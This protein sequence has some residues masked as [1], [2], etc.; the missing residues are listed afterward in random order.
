M[1]DTIL[2]VD[3]E[4]DL[5]AGLSRSI[6]MEL[7]CDILTADNAGTALEIIYG[8]PVDL[9]L[10]DIS[11]P[12]KNGMEL[13]QEISGKKPYVTV[14]MMTG[15]G[16]IEIAVESIKH[17]AYDFIQKPFDMQPLVRLLEKG[18]ERNRLIRENTRLS[19]L[20]GNK[21]P[22]LNMIGNSPPMHE[23][24]AKINMLAK[25]DVTVLITGETGTGKE[26]AARAVHGSSSRGDNAMITVNCPAL[27]EN[28][29]ES[30][31]FGYKKGAF[32]GALSDKTGLFDQADGSTIFLDEIGDLSMAVQTKLLRVLQDKTIMPL[33]ATRSH[34]VNVRI[35][36][37]TNRNLKRK[38]RN[39]TFR[40]DLYY[41][42]NVAELSM[43]PLRRVREDIPLLTRH[44][45]EKSCRELNVP[46]KTISAEVVDWLMKKEWPGNI[47][48]LE[49]TI[50]GWCAVIPD[51]EI[52][53]NHLP[54]FSGK[55]SENAC[56]DNF[57]IPYKD[58]K[59]NIIKD[60]T[61]SYIKRLL[62]H[63]SGNVSS[64]A[65]ISG[66]QRQSL[67][68]IIKRYN[69]KAEEFRR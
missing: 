7:D 64:A 54:G 30:E 21:G 10:T 12:D 4:K 6:K 44:F 40:P 25:T 23:T 50:Q 17:G 47:R 55:N 16:S 11:M 14:I 27:P 37:A 8:S 24:F 46:L 36:T 61:I 19:N 63:T 5:L 22:A 59:D 34:K 32:T 13:L 43:P 38:I 28:I 3:D 49:N 33:G 1:V 53:L 60:F 18:L 9:V 67:Q 58:L 69:I 20:L 45:A 2:I 15:Y 35:I 26:M 48:E 66:I 68:K 31:L 57:S 51:E 29:L 41:R 52:R 56:Y 62:M 65:K 39:N 42:L